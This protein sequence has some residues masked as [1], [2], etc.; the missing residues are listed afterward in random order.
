MRRMIECSNVR[1]E[2]KNK[3]I[4]DGNHESQN[5][6]GRRLKTGKCLNPWESTGKTHLLWLVEMAA[7]GR[8]TEWSIHGYNRW[9]RIHWCGFPRLWVSLKLCM[10]TGNKNLFCQ[11]SFKGETYG[12]E[13]KGFDP[14][15]DSLR[16]PLPFP[17]SWTNSSHVWISRAS[18]ALV[19][20]QPYLCGWENISGVSSY[21]LLQCPAL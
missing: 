20:W 4:I 10:K 6:R 2:E 12:V 15:Y 7:F 17:Y 18:A 16:F 9:P 5:R 14:F 19:Y 11:C 1:R 8:K 3:S 21:S 13:Y